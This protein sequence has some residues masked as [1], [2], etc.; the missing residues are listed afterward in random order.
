MK[1]DLSTKGN[2]RTIR[3]MVRVNFIT[4]TETSMKDIL[5]MVKELGK[6]LCCSRTVISTK[7]SLGMIKSLVEENYFSTMETSMKVNS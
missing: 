7:E 2:L 4:L 1:M 3:L 5:R 6:E